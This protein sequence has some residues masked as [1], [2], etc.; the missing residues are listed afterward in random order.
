MFY[1]LAM[2]RSG[3]MRPFATPMP[4]RPPVMISVIAASP[5]AFFA[6]TAQL[7]RRGG[8]GEPGEETLDAPWAEP[9]VTPFASMSGV[10]VG[11]VA[12]RTG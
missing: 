6:G 12:G 4:S 1:G 10:E 5:E 2:F 8:H 7:Q 9:D 11:S 3:R